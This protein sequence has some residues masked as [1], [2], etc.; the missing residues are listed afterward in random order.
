MAR[1]IPNPLDLTGRHYLVTG[2]ASGIGRA[3]AIQFAALGASISLVDMNGPQ[4]DESIASMQPGDHARYVFDLEQTEGIDT[5]VR[6]IVSADGPLHGV[7]HCAGTQTV[8]PARDLKPA[9]WRR[10]LAINC[11]AALALSKNM[12]RKR[13]YAGSSGSIVFISSIMALAGAAG[14]V[15][16]SMSKS[17]L[18]GM[19]RS[20]ALEFAPGGIRV[21]CIAPGYVRT[22]MLDRL[23]QTWDESQRD[24]VEALHPLGFGQPEDVA[25]AA[26]FLVADT[27]RWITGTVLVVDGG[28]LAR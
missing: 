2:A 5:L 16:Y 8:M 23:Q 9:T 1:T 3:I 10:I 15:A 4:M 22:P 17:A 19:A 13:V 24:A 20:L 28:Y 27:G 6:E 26:A 11:E 25:H 7:I 18:H 21:N 14:S 12:G